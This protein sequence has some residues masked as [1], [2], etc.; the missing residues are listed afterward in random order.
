MHRAPDAMS[1]N[2]RRLRPAFR[3]PTPGTGWS[4]TTTGPARGS[5]SALSRSQMTRALSTRVPSARSVTSDI[6]LA[7]LPMATTST[8]KSASSIRALVRR[9]VMSRRRSNSA[10]HCW[11]IALASVTRSETMGTFHR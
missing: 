2:A 7:A 1:R 4:P 5:L 6:S 8:P 3:L 10:S 11:L 9:S